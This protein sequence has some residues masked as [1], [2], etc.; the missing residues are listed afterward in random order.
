MSFSNPRQDY[1]DILDAIEAIDSFTEG[2]GTDPVPLPGYRPGVPSIMSIAPIL[3][4]PKRAYGPS[5]RAVLSHR[6]RSRD[7]SD[8]PRRRFT[9]RELSSR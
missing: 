6:S 4:P 5:G 8:G 2:I 9:W 7:E 1:K 3:N